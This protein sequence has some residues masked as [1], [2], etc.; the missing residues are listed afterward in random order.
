[1]SADNPMLESTSFSD[2][3]RAAVLFVICE[4]SDKQRFPLEIEALNQS[5]VFVRT[6]RRV[7]GEFVF[8]MPTVH[9]S[10][11]KKVANWCLR[12]R[13]EPCPLIVKDPWRQ[14]V[15]T[16]KFKDFELHYFNV[17]VPELVDILKAAN[18]LQ[19]ASLFHYGCQYLAALIRNKSPTDVRQILHQR[20]DLSP[21]DYAEIRDQNPWL[22]PTTPVVDLR[23]EVSTPVDIPADVLIYVFETLT[24]ADLERLQMVNSHFRNIITGV[25]KEFLRE[26]GPRRLLREVVLGTAITDRHIISTLA[27]ETIVCEDLATLAKRLEYSVIEKLVFDSTQRYADDLIYGLLP[28][29]AAWKRASVS[30]SPRNFSSK[31]VFKFAF[32]DLL[33]CKEILLQEQKVDDYVSTSILRLPATIRC[34]SLDISNLPGWCLGL[35]GPWAGRL[36][37]S[38][39]VMWLEHERLKEFSG[40]PKQLAIA[41][42]AIRRGFIDLIVE[43]KSNFWLAV[44][45]NPYT[46]R[47]RLDSKVRISRFRARHKITKEELLVAGDEADGKYWV[48]VQRK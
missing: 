46:V 38:D 9:S 27:G 28:S 17:P 45:P 31:E 19:I 4:T 30:T 14:E 1:M 47:I 6:F 11:F 5:R 12:H 37:A 25:G 33:W 36:K 29:K 44:R 40:E 22:D 42:R 34:V 24:R 41:A 35:K 16:F 2:S 39:V 15:K 21:D 10:V 3:G 32:T 7:R 13:G 43:L 8:Q 48:V 18:D 23:A 26:R 20:G